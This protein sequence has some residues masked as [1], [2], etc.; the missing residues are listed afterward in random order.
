LNTSTSLLDMPEHRRWV[1]LAN[2]LD[3][4][5]LRTEVAFKMG[6]IFD[7]LLWTPRSRQV[8]LYMNGSYVGVYQLVE[9]R[10]IDENRLNIGEMISSA[11]PG[12]SYLLEVCRRLEGIYN[13]STTR[14]RRFNLFDPS[15]GFSDL[16]EGTEI[17]LFEKVRSFVQEAEDAL[18]SV[19]F[20]DPEIGWQKYLDIDTFVDWYLVNDITKN[21]DSN[22]SS[23]VFMYYDPVNGKLNMGPL[24]D[25]DVSSGN[26]NDLRA[27]GIDVK[28]PHG[29]FLRPPPSVGPIVGWFQSLFRDPIFVAAVTQRW[30]DKKDELNTIIQ[31]LDERAAFLDIAQAQNFRRWD[32][33]NVMLWPNVVLPGTYDGEIEYLRS[34]LIERIKWFDE[35][36]NSIY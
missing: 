22:F 2:L 15:D 23:S 33:L 24:W 3:K 29:F 7:N 20:M 25:F 1:L 16:I 34:W 11:N 21:P 17:T 30:N 28:Y 14:D 10:R 12:G 8:D 36:T 4:S 9:Q 27:H 13:F 32:I 19:N 6:A 31:F 35:A 26:R 5:L 18:F